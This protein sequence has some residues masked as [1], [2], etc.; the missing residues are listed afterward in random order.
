MR[1][2]N[3]LI[4]SGLGALAN[5]F[6]PVHRLEPN[7]CSKDALTPQN[8]FRNSQTVI[9]ASTV[10]S[11]TG[12]STPPTLDGKRVLPFKIMNAG[13]KGSTVA[14]VY[15]L[16]NTDYKK[17]YVNR[18]EF[19]SVHDFFTGYRCWEQNR[20][21]GCRVVPELNLSKSCSPIIYLYHK[22]Q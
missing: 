18:T 8:S 4:V 2:I 17:G 5:G 16:L 20:L 14:A 3:L 13:V 10:G 21:F 12:V 19:L 15:A 1:Q 9:L 11:S 6:L 22:R 7:S